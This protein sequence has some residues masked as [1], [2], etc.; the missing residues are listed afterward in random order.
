MIIS[1][2]NIARSQGVVKKNLVSRLLHL[3]ELLFSDNISVSLFR[4][5]FAQGQNAGPVETDQ[6]DADTTTKERV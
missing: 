2:Y 1:K 4:N 3:L 5:F 6:G